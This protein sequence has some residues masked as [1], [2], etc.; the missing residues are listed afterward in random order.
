MPDVKELTNKLYGKYIKKIVQ[1]SGISPSGK[2]LDCGSFGCAYA[3]GDKVVKITQDPSEAYAA[4]RLRAVG[5]F[6][7]NVY[8][9]YRVFD[10]GR[11]GSY[12]IVQEK[13]HKP[14][15]ELLETSEAIRY[16][17]FAAPKIFEELMHDY[18]GIQHFQNVFEDYLIKEFENMEY[19]ST[20]FFRHQPENKQ[21]K[22]R[23]YE[24]GKN[25]DEFDEMYGV[26]HKIIRAL[27][28]LGVLDATEL[29]KKKI[30]PDHVRY[31]EDSVASAP[32]AGRVKMF[33]DIATGVTWPYSNGIKFYDVHEGNVMQNS[34]GDPVI[35]DLGVSRVQGEQ[36][37]EIIEQYIRRIINVRR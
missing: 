8:K 34:S 1:R 31:I 36:S 33:S 18:G 6:H 5:S 4:A 17:S 11:G 7:K 35:I 26:T 28:Q 10:L 20:V 27:A 15:S 2:L 13:L 24:F 23:F 3:H 21:E 12:A 16:L 30:F 25:S 14:S 32:E 19:D 22:K 29:N 9:I 37:M